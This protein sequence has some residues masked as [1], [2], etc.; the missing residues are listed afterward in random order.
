[1]AIIERISVHSVH[2]T[3]HVLVIMCAIALV[4][5]SAGEVFAEEYEKFT[6]I[7]SQLDRISDIIDEF[8]PNEFGQLNVR[9]H[10]V[11]NEINVMKSTLS[12]NSKED[13]KK[14]NELISKFENIS[15][16]FDIITTKYLTNSIPLEKKLLVLD[17]KKTISKLEINHH[18]FLATIN[19]EK[20]SRD[21]V[22]TIHYNKYIDAKITEVIV[23]K[24]ILDEKINWPE[25]FKATLEKIKE[26]RELNALPTAIDRIMLHYTDEEI[27]QLLMK[28]R[29]DIQNS[30]QKNSII[31]NEDNPTTLSE[32]KSEDSENEDIE[33]TPFREPEIPSALLMQIDNAISLIST[34]LDTHETIRQQT[35]VNSLMS[36]SSS[37]SNLGASSGGH[38]D[39]GRDR[40]PNNSLD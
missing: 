37:K 34:S 27:L 40:G 39:V 19:S 31:S 36:V 33:D 1:M 3:S 15:E 22:D 7:E 20:Y 28:A 23:E 4:Q 26:D 13:F 11:C 12:Y 38:S 6:K 17:T 35:I 18:Q 24:T 29:D 14:Y 21:Q 16:K 5:F 30:I 10:S 8:N 2:T 32:D 25:I 9:F